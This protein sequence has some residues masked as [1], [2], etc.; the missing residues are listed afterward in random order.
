VG[1]ALDMF[2]RNEETKPVTSLTYLARQEMAVV[3]WNKNDR[4]LGIL[5]KTITVDNLSKNEGVKIFA[6]GLERIHAWYFL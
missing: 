2:L 1:N 3:L 5:R 6:T 4:T